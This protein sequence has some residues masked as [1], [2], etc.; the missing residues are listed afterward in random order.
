M[1]RG[2][3]ELASFD[4]IGEVLCPLEDGYKFLVEGAVVAFCAVKLLREAR[5]CHA[6]SMCCSIIAPTPVS[7]TWVAMHVT[8]SGVG[9]LS[10]GTSESAF[11]TARKAAL[12]SVVQISVMD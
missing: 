11:L 7:E 3:V 10:E 5:G 6:P 12:V 4:K 2:D 8:A 1:V 9:K